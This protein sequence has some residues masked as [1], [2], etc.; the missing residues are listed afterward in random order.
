MKKLRK[1]K[2]NIRE[3]MKNNNQN[4]TF[5]RLTVPVEKG[6]VYKKSDKQQIGKITEVWWSS[7]RERC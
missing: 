6:V 7:Q 3:Q 4:L 2:D 5:H 1:C